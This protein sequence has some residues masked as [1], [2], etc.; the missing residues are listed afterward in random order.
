M[1]CALYGPKALVSVRRCVALRQHQYQLR[2]AN[3]PKTGGRRGTS[4]GV[5]GSSGA[6]ASGRRH[7]GPEGEPEP[8]EQ[9]SLMGEAVSGRSVQR[10]EV[11][12]RRN[13]GVYGC[14]SGSCFTAVVVFQPVLVRWRVQLYV[15]AGRTGALAQLSRTNKHTE[16]QY[17]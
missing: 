9:V 5:C 1:R 10:K 12:E 13:W 14:G 3:N 6:G 4:G 15:G 2:R 17:E 7:G 8:K 11:G 16:L